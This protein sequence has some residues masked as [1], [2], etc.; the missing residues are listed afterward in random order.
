MVWNLLTRFL[1][2]SNSSTISI[3]STIQ[4]LGMQC[5]IR[6]SILKGFILQLETQRIKQGISTQCGMCYKNAKYCR[7]IQRVPN[8]VQ[9][10]RERFLEEAQEGIFL[11]RR[12]V[13]GGYRGPSDD[14]RCRELGIV[15]LVMVE[16]F[17]AE[18]MCTNAQR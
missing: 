5:S 17:K 9:W 15:V 10:D 2:S 12:G 8:P 7:R 13:E 16:V 6:N 1:F 14:G 11:G 4:K 3:P 18:R